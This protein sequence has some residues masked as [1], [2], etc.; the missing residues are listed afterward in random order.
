MPWDMGKTHGMA[1]E[2]LPGGYFLGRFPDSQ[3]SSRMPRVD[4]HPGRG[5][6]GL[7]SWHPKLYS[8]DI[9]SYQT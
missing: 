3:K 7:I 6:V 1:L 8:L 9:Q 4:R 2:W 5:F